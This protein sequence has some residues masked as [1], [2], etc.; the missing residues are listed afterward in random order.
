MTSLWKYSTKTTSKYHAKKTVVDGITFDSKKEA[1]HYQELKLLERAGEIHDLKL[2]VPFVL[3]DKSA[4]GRQI[5][6]VADFVYY[7]D[8][9]MV[10]EDVKGFKTD[11]YKLKKRL[12][13]ERYEIEIKEI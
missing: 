5:K 8:G 10:V 12:M 2:Q 11:V 3:I 9:Q 6:Y 1:T 13:A 7:Q 4:H